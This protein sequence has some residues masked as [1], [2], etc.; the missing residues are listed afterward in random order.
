MVLFIFFLLAL[1]LLLSFLLRKQKSKN[2]HLPPGPKGLPF[3]GNLHQFDSLN[4]HSYLW[5]LS[6]KYGPLMSL[7]LGFVPILVVSSAKMAKEI[8][9]THDL[10]FCS[11]PSLVGQQKLSYNGLDL[12]FSP[13]N[14]YWRE[15]R[16]I[17]MVYLFNSNRVQSFRPIRE[18]EVSHMLEKISK[19]AAALKPVNLSEVMMS[20]TS[21]IICRVAFGKRYEED[22]VERS[23]FHE[24]LKETQAM[25]TSFFVSDY[26]P[27]SG[28]IDKFTG[29]AHRLEKNFKEFDIFYE[30]IIQEH[31]DPS[32][33]KPGEEDILDI[34]LQ[35]YKNRS[36]KVD[37]TFDHIKAVL[38]NVFVGGTDTGAATVVWAMTFLMK[39]STA[40]M[41]AQEEVRKLVG[42]KGFVEEDDTQQLPYLKAVIK[43]TMRLQPTVP[44]LVPRESS[45][46]CTLDG[47]DIPA[48]TVVYVNAWAIGRDPEIWENPEKFDPERFINSSIDLKGQDF[49]LIPFGAGRRIC[50]GI[51]MGL[52]T[53]EVSLANLLCKFDW[54]IPVGMKKEELDMDAQPGITMHKKNALCLMARKYA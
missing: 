26:Y 32:R 43:E 21:T 28:F 9:K 23:R 50:P 42:K 1:P 39:N 36:F 13:Y 10:I 8:L 35:L 40:M 31:L 18:F 54:E 16:K 17:C 48:K 29:L 3:I 52:A 27:F 45:E 46:N 38:M 12:A 20:L 30:Q 5:Q 14:A 11:R 4:P 19:S 6:Q 47:Y 51:F 34:L 7:R 37:L 15:I 25:F 44:L 53:V 41:K 33:S 49:E 2:R 22:G 24:L